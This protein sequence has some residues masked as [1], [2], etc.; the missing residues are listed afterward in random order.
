MGFGHDNLVMIIVMSK[1][2]LNVTLFEILDCNLNK[3]SFCIEDIP[4]CVGTLQI[5]FFFFFNKRIIS[6]IFN[7]FSLLFFS[8]S[9]HQTAKNNYFLIHFSFFKYR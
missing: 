6:F 8:H 1:V 9:L 5:L 7:L 2:M 4:K 3:F